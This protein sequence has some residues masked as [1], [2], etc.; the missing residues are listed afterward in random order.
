LV[1]YTEVKNLKETQKI[2]TH[3][4]AQKKHTY[5]AV[6]NLKETHKSAKRKFFEQNPDTYQHGLSEM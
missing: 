6:E 5:T 2:K 3:K 1:W 4:S